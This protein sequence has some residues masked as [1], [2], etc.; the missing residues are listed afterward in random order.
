MRLSCS[1]N[2]VHSLFQEW[3][4]VNGLGSLSCSKNGPGSMPSAP[5]QEAPNLR[6]QTEKENE[7]CYYCGIVL[8]FHIM[9]RLMVSVG[10]TR[11]TGYVVQPSKDPWWM[12]ATSFQLRSLHPSASYL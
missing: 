4:G 6:C 12:V 1:R 2:R 3:A 5:V 9:A 10:I 11:D 7:H 8:F